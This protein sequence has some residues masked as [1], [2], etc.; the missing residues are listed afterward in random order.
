MLS[1]VEKKIAGGT[2][3]IN[4]PARLRIDFEYHRA[5]FLGPAT[6]SL[7]APFIASIN[8]VA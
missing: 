1:L 5:S 3:G 4:I 7:F 2:N 8:F 6:P